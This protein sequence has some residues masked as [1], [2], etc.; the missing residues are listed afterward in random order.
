MSATKLKKVVVAQMALVYKR[1][2]TS[3]RE[4]SSNSGEP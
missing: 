2:G 4:S 3:V 1:E